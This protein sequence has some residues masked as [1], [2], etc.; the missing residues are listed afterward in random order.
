MD[1]RM[2]VIDGVAAT[3]HIRRDFPNMTMLRTVDDDA[4]VSRALQGGANGYLLKD[5]PPADLAKADARRN[6][7]STS[8]IPQ[9]PRS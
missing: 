3:V 7:L 5:L 6:S 2:P 8:W 9:S 4:L 1:V